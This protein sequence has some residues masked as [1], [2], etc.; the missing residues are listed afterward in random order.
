MQA[1]VGHFF[2]GAQHIR[3]A[4]GCHAVLFAVCDPQDLDRLIQMPLGRSHVLGFGFRVSGL[5]FGFR[6]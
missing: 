4:P 3:F 6:I 2:L 5:G 1:V